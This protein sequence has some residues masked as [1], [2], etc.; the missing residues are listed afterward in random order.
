MFYSDLGTAVA[1]VVTQKRFCAAPVQICRE[2]LAELGTQQ[3]IRALV[4]NTGNANAGTG[5]SGYQNAMTVC[6]ALADALGCHVS[7]ILP[8]STG[9]ILEPLPID[10][11]LAGLPIALANLSADNWLNAVQER[12][13]TA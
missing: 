6:Q 10:R 2:H 7:Q 9:V 1:G 12:I 11:I 3:T 5:E 8:F 13:V 4:I